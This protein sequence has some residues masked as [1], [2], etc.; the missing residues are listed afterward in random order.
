[1]E[2]NNILFFITNIFLCN[3]KGDRQKHAGDKKWSMGEKTF[4]FSQNIS[5]PAPR[6]LKCRQT[7]HLHVW[8]Q[9][10]SLIN[11]L[12]SCRQL[13]NPRKV[14][15]VFCSLWPSF[16]KKKITFCRILN[17]FCSLWKI[18][19]DSRTIYRSVTTVTFLYLKLS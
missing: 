1:M 11:F 4:F 9:I 15:Y 3:F 7:Q 6:I 14:Y 13:W 10:L 16:N 12:P 5:P 19:R 2:L 8:N 17:S 18:D